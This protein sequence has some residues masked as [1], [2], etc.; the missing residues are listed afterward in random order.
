MSSNT[1]GNDA[2]RK[3]TSPVA[4]A[5]AGSLLL[6]GCAGAGDATVSVSERPLV[7]R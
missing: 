6:A 3:R 5:A 2:K 4:I 7:F 1:S